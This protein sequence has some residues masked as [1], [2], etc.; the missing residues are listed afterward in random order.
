MNY[1]PLFDLMSEE[2]GL[3]LLESDMH[4]IIN[5]VKNLETSKDNEN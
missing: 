5:C 1:Q 4:E 3:T 2:F